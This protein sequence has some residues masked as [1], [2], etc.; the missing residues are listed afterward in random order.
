M[1]L[2]CSGMNALISP[3]TFE[4][5]GTL[6]Q[7]EIPSKILEDEW[8]LFQHFCRRLS[9]FWHG[10]VVVVWN[11]VDYPSQ[12]AHPQWPPNCNKDSLRRQDRIHVQSCI[13]WIDPW[14]PSRKDSWQLSPSM[15]KD[16]FICNVVYVPVLPVP[17]N[18]FGAYLHQQG[19]GFM[20]SHDT[21]MHV[22]F[23]SMVLSVDMSSDCY[24]SYKPLGKSAT[25]STLHCVQPP[26]PPN[27]TTLYPTKRLTL[28]A[29]TGPATTLGLFNLRKPAIIN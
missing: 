5:N 13:Q 7:Q 2:P 19:C 24:P 22:Y 4:R 15:D 6:P 11:N 8:Q 20:G 14:S 25:L 1:P 3:Y 17:L 28:C 12:E 27:L 23:P 21:R 18:S 16:I 9:Y 26:C 10:S 29:C